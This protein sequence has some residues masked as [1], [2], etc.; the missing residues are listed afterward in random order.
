MTIIKDWPLYEASAAPESISESL[1]KARAQRRRLDRDI[2]RLEELLDR[3]TRE[4]DAGTWPPKE[5]Q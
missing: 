4:R 1:G 5:Q 3:R 2:A